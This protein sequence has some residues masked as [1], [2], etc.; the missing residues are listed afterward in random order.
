MVLGDS[1]IPNAVNYLSRAKEVNPQNDP[2][3]C[4][5]LGDLYR[6]NFVEEKAAA[7][8]RCFLKYAT[9]DHPSRRRV[10]RALQTVEKQ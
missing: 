10:E 9:T 6:Q 5:L 8:Y 1:E 2:T 3:P 4:L 7:E